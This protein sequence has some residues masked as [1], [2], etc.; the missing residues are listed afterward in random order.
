[1]NTIKTTLVMLSAM[2]SLA[3]STIVVAGTTE[4]PKLQL[5]TYDMTLVVHEGAPPEISLVAVVEVDEST[6]A[7]WLSA[8]EGDQISFSYT[9]SELDTLQLLESEGLV[10]YNDSSE[11]AL[12]AIIASEMIAYM[13]TFDRVGGGT[14]A[15][16]DS[17]AG[18]TI[19]ATATFYDG[20]EREVTMISYIG[21]T[22]T[23]APRLGIDANQAMTVSAATADGVVLEVI[24][25]A[26]GQE[27]AKLLDGAGF[28]TLVSDAAT[29]TKSANSAYGLTIATATWEQ[30]SP[31]PAAL[32]LETSTGDV[33]V[34]A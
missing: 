20:M 11:S 8:R 5:I 26:I 25:F 12:D 1:M 15:T 7:K 27:A 2:L 29:A 16:P 13:E 31:V 9:L 10:A 22:A 6:A 24:A 18:V 30:F 14:G 28:S 4:S 32:S 33:W 21:E 17:A 3:F 19:V 23:D 34:R